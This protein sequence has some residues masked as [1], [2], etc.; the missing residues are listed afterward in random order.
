M[1][2][3]S[4]PATF[5]AYQAKKEKKPA[6]RLSAAAKEFKFN[7]AALFTPPGDS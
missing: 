7:V 6:T 2:V 4:S 1:P 5:E 3:Y